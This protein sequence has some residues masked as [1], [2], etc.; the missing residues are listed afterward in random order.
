MKV[1]QLLFLTIASTMCL[2]LS[3]SAS[4]NSNIDTDTT[5]DDYIVSPLGPFLSRDQYNDFREESL[6]RNKR[7]EILEGKVIT[8][9]TKDK[10]GCKAI[11]AEMNLGQDICKYDPKSPLVSVIVMRPAEDRDYFNRK[12]NFSNLSEKEK[13]GL[14]S[15]L[16]FGIMGVGTMGIIYAMPESISKWDKSKGF[17]DLASQY[18][19]R[20]KAGPVWDHDNWAVNYIGHPIAGAMYYT[21][22]RH[23]G[24]TPLESAAFTFC[25]STF[26]W[27][28]GLEALAEVP[29]IQDLIITP[30]VGSIIGEVFYSWGNAIENNGGTLLGSK[31]LGKTATIL[32]NPAA[33]VANQVNKLAKYNFIQEPEFS[34]TK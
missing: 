33:S 16:D 19:N 34:I 28:Y 25:M 32:M 12:I 18:T 2:S 30:L 11:Q 20:V 14:S 4:T 22:V 27:E 5:L 10:E 29:S 7:S 23:Q 6:V 17:S 13:V 31:F 24:Y 26:F 15:L 21:V 9:N 1:S 8:I 3:L